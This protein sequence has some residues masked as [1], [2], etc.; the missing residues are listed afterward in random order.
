MFP[1]GVG[2]VSVTGGWAVCFPEVAGVL[3]NAVL[4]LGFKSGCDN[5]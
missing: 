1:A 4:V 5:A 3:T 2:V